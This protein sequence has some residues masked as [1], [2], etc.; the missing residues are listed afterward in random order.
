MAPG[1]MIIHAHWSMTMDWARKAT[2]CSGRYL[3]LRHHRTYREPRIACCISVVAVLACLQR[4]NSSVRA[5]ECNV[6]GAAASAQSR[7]K[8]I[9]AQGDMVASREKLFVRACPV[10]RCAQRAGR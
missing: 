1:C 3:Q 10:N 8:A 9:S 2:T 6:L 7:Q 4:C 5:S